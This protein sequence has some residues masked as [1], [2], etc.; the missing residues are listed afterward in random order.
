MKKDKLNEEYKYTRDKVETRTGGLAHDRINEHP[1]YDSDKKKATEKFSLQVVAWCIIG[2]IVLM[3]VATLTGC[4]NTPEREVTLDDYL[5]G[6]EQHA[7]DTM[8]SIMPRGSGII[9]YGDGTV[10]SIRWGYKDEDVMWI[11]GNGDTI[12]E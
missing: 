4:G 5:D 11:G 8:Q 12:W 1:Y 2:I 7:L 10:D 9:E 3:I 6:T